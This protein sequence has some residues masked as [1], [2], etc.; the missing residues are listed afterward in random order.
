[1]RN[2]YETLSSTRLCLTAVATGASFACLPG[3]PA[4]GQQAPGQLEEVQVTGTRIQRSGFAS[5]TP[6]TVMSSEDLE[7]LNPGP[8]VDAIAVSPQFLNNQLPSDG[9]TFGN[10]AGSSSLNLRGIGS[11]RMLVLLDGRRVVPSV[12]GTVNI[13]LLPEALVQRVEVVTGGAS[14]AYGSDA[15]SGVTNFVLDTEFTGVDGHLQGGNIAAHGDRET[16]EASFAGGAELSERAHILGTV[17]FFRAEEVFGWDKRDWFQ[18]YAE[19]RNLDP[20]GPAFITVPHIRSTLYTYG[21]LIPSGPLAGTEF[22]EDGTPARF[23][24]GDIPAPPFGQSGGSG[25][26]SLRDN[27][28]Y[29][30]VERKN[31]FLYFDYDVT[32]DVTAYVQGLYGR[33]D[34]IYSVSEL[35]LYN[36]IGTQATIFRDNAFLPESTG[37]AMDDAGIDSFTL[38]RM[39]SFAD[40]TDLE[41]VFDE[42]LSLTLGAE[43][44]LGNWRLTAYYQNGENER[45]FEGFQPRM[46]HVYPALDAVVDPATGQTV[47]RSTLTN[48]NDGCRPLN[49][50]G[51][52]QMSAEAVD[53]V[54]GT[55]YGVHEIEQNFAEIAIDGEIARNR[56]AGSIGVA[57]GVS[58]RDETLDARELPPESEVSMPEAGDVAYMGLPP[59][60]AGLEWVF[61]HSEILDSVG[62][63]DVKEVF[64]EAIVPLVT[65]GRLDLTVA[66]RYADYSGSG[67]VPAWKVGLDW[68]ATDGVR[69]RFTRSRDIRAANLEERF[70]SQFIGATIDDPFIGVNDIQPPNRIRFGGNPEVDPEEADT[71]VVGGVFQPSGVDGLS[72]S[73]DFYDVDIQGAI[74]T[75]GAQ[76]LVDLCFEAGSFCDQLEQDPETGQVMRV[77]DLYVNLT[78]AQVTGADLELAYTTPIDGLRFRVLGSYLREH[79]FTDQ[80]GNTVD[81]A[82]ETGDSSLPKRQALVSGFYSTGPVTVA[83]TNRYIGSGKRD[84]FEIEGV[85]IDDNSVDD[86]WYTDLRLS[87]EAEMTGG[88]AWELFANVQNLFDKSPP[89]APGGFSFFSGTDQTNIN[90][91]DT[92]G[93]RYTLGARFRY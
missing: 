77:N 65:E 85:D 89:L 70:N 93:R 74:D 29:P 9:G 21:G 51:R 33:S 69:F 81:S 17:D 22:L 46:D 75:V 53:Y 78:K 5:A 1:M 25:V 2:L 30:E 13:S 59:A 66:G 4:L 80:F 84:N 10:T 31:G 36:V 71:W 20:N 60:L 41:Q 7:I 3:G 86:V 18:D 12:R 72:L 76:T 92:L 16:Y 26:N 68:Q 40:W 32:D 48:P 61:Q 64:A 83:V 62:G 57:A 54:M 50:F 14:A 6:V 91:F 38:N 37:A 52:G 56:R 28:M 55:H 79:S 43:A 23:V 8:L 88:G 34:S 27:A 58:W 47:C 19:I 15:V 87:Y 24:Q 67:S 90:L 73:V 44:D 39:S 49:L 35:R 82:G 45:F 63:Y 11:N 42:T